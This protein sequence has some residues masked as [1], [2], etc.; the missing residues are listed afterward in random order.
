[1]ALGQRPKKNFFFQG[2]A[3]F[4]QRARSVIKDFFLLLFPF[5]LAIWALFCR[6]KGAV[7][8]INLG[9]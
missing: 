3:G 9:G 1:M 4:R 8:P 2:G 7:H 6:P 5:A